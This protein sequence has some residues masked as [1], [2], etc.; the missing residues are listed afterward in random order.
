[1]Q[2]LKLD[3]SSFNPQENKRDERPLLHSICRDE[4]PSLHNILLVQRGFPPDLDSQGKQVQQN[5]EGL[6]GK[7]KPSSPQLS[8]AVGLMGSP[9][10]HSFNLCIANFTGWII[11]ELGLDSILIFC[12]GS[13]DLNG[14]S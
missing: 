5:L 4:R 9:F 3:P 8:P 12:L 11:S 6:L 2:S 7:T 10:G 13:M 1:M 14:S